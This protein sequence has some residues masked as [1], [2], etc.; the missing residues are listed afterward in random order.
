MDNRCWSGSV[1]HLCSI[2]VAPQMG[3]VSSSWY[4]V[5]DTGAAEPCD[6]CLLIPGSVVSVVDRS[7]DRVA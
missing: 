5:Y 1:L 2:P 4:Q 6:D 3:A 7:S